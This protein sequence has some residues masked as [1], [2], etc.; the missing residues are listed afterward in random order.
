[1]PIAVAEADAAAAKGSGRAIV[2]LIVDAAM[3]GAIRAA[4][5]KIDHAMIVKTRR[6]RQRAL[7]IRFDGRLDRSS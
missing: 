2:E 1:M 7:P 6:Q 4:A 3:V 5:E